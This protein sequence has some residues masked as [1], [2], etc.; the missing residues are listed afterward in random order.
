M[1]Y[2]QIIQMML[3]MSGGMSNSNLQPGMPMGTQIMQQVGSSLFGEG[4]GNV[5]GQMLGPTVNKAMFGSGPFAGFG[6]M[7]TQYNYASRMTQYN[8]ELF[9]KGFSQ[10]VNAQVEAQNQAQYLQMTQNRLGSDY[11]KGAAEAGMGSDPRYWM[12]KTM[13]AMVGPSQVA[14]GVRD[15]ATS[16]GYVFGAGFS[17]DPTWGDDNRRIKENITNMSSTMINSY[18]NEGYK[19]G[20]LTGRDT[21]D[22]IREMGKRGELNDM[23]GAVMGDD[24]ITALKDKIQ[25][26]SQA[27]SGIRDIIKGSIPEVLRQLESA[28]GGDSIN[29]L[30]IQKVSQGLQRYRQMSESTGTSL[31]DMMQYARASGSIAQQVAGYSEG[32]MG[33]GQTISAFMAGGP[34]DM[35]GIDST[36]YARTATER[37]T[38]AQLSETGLMVSGALSLMKTDAEKNA[39]KAKLA[40]VKGPLSA[41]IIA[42]LSGQSTGDIVSAS[43]SREARDIAATD[44]SGTYAAL[45]SS[46]SFYGGY[47]KDILRRGLGLSD[48]DA[49]KASK[50]TLREIKENFKDIN[51]AALGAIT[52]QLDQLALAAGFNNAEEQ[53]KFYR[54]AERSGRLEKLA[55]SKA[56]W[57][58][59]MQMVG[60]SIGAMVRNAGGAGGAMSTSIGDNMK[61]LFNIM[62]KNGTID[63]KTEALLAGSFGT[64]SM[65]AMRKFA[66]KDDKFNDARSRIINQEFEKLL[67]GDPSDPEFAKQ[68]KAMSDDPEKFWKSKEEDYQKTMKGAIGMSGKGVAYD[69]MSYTD[70]I[71]AQRDFAGKK[72]AERGALDKYATGKNIFK[73]D[74]KTGKMVDTGEKEYINVD[75]DMKEDFTR[76]KELSNKKDRTAK[77]NEDLDT[78]IHKRSKNLAEDEESQKELG[79]GPTMDMAEAITK[80]YELIFGWIS[81]KKADDSGTKPTNP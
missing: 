67:S 25:K 47:R 12:M 37:I 31:Q 80:I 15:T 54:D 79:S 71:A 38:G 22:L 35:R 28:F 49:E 9:T 6:G 42:E 51:T 63:D 27:M 50:M 34:G 60:G 57:A 55:T 23:G 26:T 43:R 44:N 7:G 10:Q 29:T 30:G 68:L 21:G 65:E 17:N 20:N 14:Y 39:F 64:S 5:M 16:M 73:K 48:T 19:Y 1:N 70:K 53:T 46:E 8:Q 77:D 75:K 18:M 3:S 74:E 33:A 41:S 62:R 45:R 69:D 56:E 61:S 78:L 52:P 81:N 11:N 66:H 13:N 4:M 2:E 59:G 40:D 58:T 36:A 24:K 32:A 72:A 76:I